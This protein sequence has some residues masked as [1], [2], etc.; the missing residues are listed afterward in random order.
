MSE[1]D[2]SGLLKQFSTMVNS[3]SLPDNIKDALN[4]FNSS[5][6][7]SSSDKSDSSNEN[8]NTSS[9]IPNIDIEMLLKIK[10]IMDK[11]NTKNDPRTNLLL[12][13]K[14]YLN[15][16]RK[17]KLEQYIQFLNLSKVFEAFNSTGGD[18]NKG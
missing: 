1:E 8:S 14:P 7:S 2:M 13:L 17:E 15:D 4:H 5:E 12:S 3:N 10:S 18:K 16:V 9:S 6:S 11:V